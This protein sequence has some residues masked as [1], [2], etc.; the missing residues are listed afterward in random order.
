MDVLPEQKEYAP[1]DKARFQVR[2]PFRSATALVTVEREGVIDSFVTRL[3]GREPVIEVPVKDDYA[4][5][6]YVSVLAVRGRVSGWRAWLADMT[7]KYHLPLRFDGGT[8]TALVDLNKPAFKLGVASIRVGWSAQRLAVSV[9][10]QREVYRVRERAL[11]DVEVRREN[12]AALPAGAEIAL[13]AVDEGLLE[14]RANDS[15]ALLDFMMNERPLEVWTSTAQMQVVGKRHYGRKAV[16]HGGGG[17]RAGA[18]ELFDTLVLWKGR[19]R[20]DANGRARIEVPLNDSLTSFRIVASRA[21]ERSTS[22][23]APPTCGPRRT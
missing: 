11:V 7:R 19:V 15:W 6:I 13:A 2:M 3:S 12:G 9:K 20:L 23:P 16:V 5:N 4:P 22:E 18:R 14:L 21:P 10:P 17:G 1:G 8:E